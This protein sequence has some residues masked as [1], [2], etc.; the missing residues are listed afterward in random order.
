MTKKFTQKEFERIIIKKAKEITDMPIDYREKHIKLEEL[1]ILSIQML[2]MNF[3]G[4]RTHRQI[5][6]TIIGLKLKV[7]PR[8]GE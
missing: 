6:N 4:M 2:D 3:I 5:N 1:N 8:L 7:C